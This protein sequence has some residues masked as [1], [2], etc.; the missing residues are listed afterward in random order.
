MPTYVYRCR[1]CR[2]HTEALQKMT[3]DP[4]TTCVSCGGSISRVVQPVGIVF[5]GS[6]FYV[7]DYKRAESAN[8]K[9]AGAENGKSA[10]ST[11]GKPE[12]GE[13]KP[14]PTAEKKEPAPAPAST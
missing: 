8:G 2:T 6:G 12:G 4:L 9:S 7:N 5:K 11:N 3:D 10:P 13:T 1:D 14:A